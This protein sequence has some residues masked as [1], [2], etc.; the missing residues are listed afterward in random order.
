MNLCRGGL[1]DSNVIAYNKQ[2]RVSFSSRFD[3]HDV[4]LL[5]D[6]VG[7]SGKQTGMGELCV[8]FQDSN[9]SAPGARQKKKWSVVPLKSIS[10]SF[11]IP[12]RPSLMMA[13]CFLILD[14]CSCD[15]SPNQWPISET[16]HLSVSIIR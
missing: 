7:R 6:R 11:L 1:T 14:E 15:V 8:L 10:K 2:R 3:D 16:D 13:I 9:K 5:A 12:L 4:D